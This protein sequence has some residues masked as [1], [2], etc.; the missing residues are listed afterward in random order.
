V[1][2][3]EE[4]DLLDAAMRAGSGEAPTVVV[5]AIAGAGGV[6]KS[7]L[8]LHWAHRNADRYPRWAALRRLTWLQ[9]RQ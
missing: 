6:G 3:L 9:P 5:A 7:W 8:A 1:G 2:R 4:L